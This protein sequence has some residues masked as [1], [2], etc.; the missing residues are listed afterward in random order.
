MF[1]F[2]FV[3]VSV[4]LR[5]SGDPE[6]RESAPEWR[7]VLHESDQQRQ[8]PD[9]SGGECYSNSKYVTW[10][11]MP[12]QYGYMRATQQ[13]VSNLGFY[14]LSTT[15]CFTPSQQLDGLRPVNNL[16]FYA[17]STTWCFTPSQQLGVLCPVNN[18]VFCAQSTTWCFVPSQPVQLYEDDTRTA[19]NNKSPTST[20]NRCHPLE[21]MA[22]LVFLL[23]GDHD[24]RLHHLLALIEWPETG[25]WCR[26]TCGASRHRQL[27]HLSIKRR[28]EVSTLAT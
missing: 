28:A 16:V 3:F 4:Q 18:L 19:T 11:F 22:L 26:A 8:L 14:D 6:C 7:T 2:E 21:A 10:C 17:Q 15:W 25:C 12:S 5:I 24:E 27:Q 20:D 23:V 9:C 1:E 13:Q